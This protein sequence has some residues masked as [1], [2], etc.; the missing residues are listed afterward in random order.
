VFT[1]RSVA[2]IAN[3]TGYIDVDVRPCPPVVHGVPSRVRA[4][5]WKF[6]SGMM[7]LAIAAE[8]GQRHDQIVTQNMT[9]VAHTGSE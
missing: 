5:I 1:P 8:T 2:Q 6:V 4:V 7:K 3:A 9:F